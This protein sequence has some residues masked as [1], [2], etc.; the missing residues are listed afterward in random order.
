MELRLPCSR[1]DVI[2]IELDAVRDTRHEGPDDR[3]LTQ[4]RCE[5]DGQMALSAQLSY[6]APDGY[7]S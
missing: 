4:S 5:P 7:P 3:A 2:F 6:A 1:H